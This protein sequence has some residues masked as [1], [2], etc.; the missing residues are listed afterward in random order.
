MRHENALIL[1]GKAPL[2][3]KVKTRL[4]PPLALRDAAALYACILSD[5]AEEMERLRGVERYLFFTPAEA[6]AHFRA[7]PF[8][9]YHLRPQ[10]GDDLGERMERAIGE[11]FN[12]GARRVAVVG[13]DCPALSAARVRSA[14][15]EL[16]SAA[17]AVF[18]PADD[19]GFYLVGLGGPSPALFGG[20]EWSTGSVL[21]AVLSRCRNAGMA[22]AL[23]PRESDVDTSEDLA[24]LRRWARG[25]ATPACPRTRK[26]LAAGR[27]LTS[28][29]A[30]PSSRRRAG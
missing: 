23:L 28:G 25:H 3:G 9:G 26:W 19:G 18:G 15:R 30:R 2:P 17:D 10:E 29:Q 5:V 21:S 24:A 11:A 7:G 1:M 20:I 12:N 8:G 13:S 27:R 14:F 4:C 16:S 6:S 22:Y